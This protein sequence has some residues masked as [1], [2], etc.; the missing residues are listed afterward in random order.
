MHGILASLL[1]QL[2]KDKAPSTWTVSELP[3]TAP[4]LFIWMCDGSKLGGDE[5]PIPFRGQFDYCKTLMEECAKLA[6]TNTPA[7]LVYMESLLTAGQKA[8]I[9]EFAAGIPNLL[10]V[11]YENFDDLAVYGEVDDVSMLFSQKVEESTT[12]FKR[13]E[14]RGGKPGRLMENPDQLGTI[15]HLVDL[16]RMALLYD[17]TALLRT[18]SQFNEGKSALLPPVDPGIVYRDFDVTIKGSRMAAPLKLLN[19][20]ACSTNLKSLI[21]RVSRLRQVRGISDRLSKTQV[22]YLRDVLLPENYADVYETVA[23]KKDMARL[24]IYQERHKKIM[25]NQASFAEDLIWYRK[26]SEGLG[27][28]VGVENS[29]LA[30]S[31]NKDPDLAKHFLDFSGRDPN[32]L[33]YTIIQQVFY[34]RFS[35]S[36]KDCYLAKFNDDLTLRVLESVRSVHSIFEVSNDLTWIRGGNEVFGKRASKEAEIERDLAFSMFSVCHCRSQ[37]VSTDCR[38]QVLPKP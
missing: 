18:A 8:K 1:S 33:P 4:H 27:M 23:L 3:I 2:E 12:C 28:G 34:P 30:F 37:P 13:S 35:D 16:S 38:R 36:E 17:I 11:S 19:R 31:G 32:V 10:T 22:Q 26:T 24:Q 29:M 14:G 7:I 21:G 25:G 6:R 9:A 5:M 20:K 15:A